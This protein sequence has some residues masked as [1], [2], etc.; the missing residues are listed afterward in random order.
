MA[1]KSQQQ[2]SFS[3]RLA[4]YRPVLDRTIFGVALLGMLVVAHLGIQEKRGFAEGC[5][6][7]WE[8][9]PARASFNCATVTQSGASELLGV[10]NIIWGFLFY[11]A[12]AALT[13]A[14]AFVSRSARRQLKLGRAGLIG[15]GFLYSAYL[16]YYQ[17][18][19]IEALCALCLV[20]AGLIAMLLVLQV[21]DYTTSKEKSTAT[22]PF[23]KMKREA[24]LLTSLTVL[25]IVLIGA[26]WMYFRDAAPETVTAEAAERA[27]P[28]EQR[29]ATPSPAARARAMADSLDLPAGCQFDPELEPV[30]DYAQ[31]INAEDPAFGPDDAPVTVIEFLD[32]NCPHCRTLHPVM[33]QVVGQHG[34]QVQLVYKPMPLWRFSLPQIEALFAAAEED[35]FEEMLEAQFARQQ[36]N[37][38]SMGE[39]R[40]IAEE[41]G[42]DPDALASQINEDTYQDEAMQQRQIAQQ[43]G[44]NSVPTVIINGHFVETRSRTPQCMSAMIEAFAEES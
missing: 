29:A 3:E 6:G 11:T 20:S 33:Q 43:I 12:V 38:L 25:L 17:F 7:F 5:V 15:G 37:G 23:S 44:I 22:M 10:S 4:D 27:A 1:Q 14:I 40:Q 39:L 16:V 32:P 24:A 42:M 28:E 30:E 19:G 8:A 34:D 13:F 2:N 41:I 35:K 36:D 9:N 21:A 26:D 31:I 18:F